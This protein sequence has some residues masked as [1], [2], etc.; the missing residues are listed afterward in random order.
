MAASPKKF[1]WEIVGVL[2]AI[3]FAA[4]LLDSARVAFEWTDV[5]HWLCVRNTARFTRLCVLC[6]SLIGILAVIRVLRGNTKDDG[7]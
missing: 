6:L 7:G 2:F 4:W 1:R 5:M 3:V